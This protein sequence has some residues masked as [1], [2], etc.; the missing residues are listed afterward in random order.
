MASP[1]EP[2]RAA[3]ADDESAV[4][5]SAVAVP[6]RDK[7]T[8]L[9]RSRVI[10]ATAVVAV[11]LA[12]GAAQATDDPL[13][14]ATTQSP[15]LVQIY[16]SP[17][18]EY[19]TPH[20][21]ATFEHSLRWQ[22]ERFGWQPTQPVTVFLKDFSDFGNAGATPTPI[23]TL[24]VEIEPASNDFETDPGGERMASLMNH[25]LVHLATGDIASS[26][27]LFWRHL[28]LGKVSPQPADPESLIYSYLTVPRFNVPRWQLEGAA[29]F[30]ETWMGGGFGRAQGG[31]DEM[32]FRAMVRDHAAFYDPLALESRGIRVDFQV[33][34]NAYLYG[35]RFM[36]W[37]A[38]TYSP[39]QVVTWLRR[40]EGSKRHYAAAFEQVFGLPLDTAWQH[41]IADEQTFQQRNLQGLREHPLTPLKPITRQAL[42]SSSRL[43]FD[44]ASATLYGAFRR[45]GIVEFVGAVDTRNGSVRPLVDLTG[46]VLFSVTA[47][48]FDPVHRTLFYTANNLDQRDLMSF[49][50]RTGRQT[51]LLRR[52][53]IG[54]LVF[55]AADRSLIGV[56]HANGVA[57]IVRVPFPYD[58]WEPLHTF[59]YEV[60]PTNLD[61][62]PDGA[63]LSASVKEVNGD[64]FL[65]VWSLA[66][67]REGRLEQTAQF[68]FGQ[69][70]PEGFVFSPDGRYLYGTSYFTG[71]SN[72]FRCEPATGATEAVTNVETGVFRPLPLADGRLVVL[73]Y[74]GQGF[75]PSIVERPVPLEDVSAIRF[76]GT[77]LAERHPVVTTWQVPPTAATDTLA[78]ATPPRPYDPRRELQFLNAYP[79][80]QGY[81]KTGGLGYRANWSD[82]L[83]FANV[84]LV[85]AVTPAQG[86]K[87]KEQGHAELSGNYL[88]YSGSLSW[89]RS[90]FYDLFGPTERSRKGPRGEGRR[91][92]PADLR[93]LRASRPAFRGR[94]LQRH[95]HAAD[96]AERR[97]HGVDA[98]DRRREPH[99][100]QPAPLARR[101][102]R[103]RRHRG[104]RCAEGQHRARRPHDPG[105]RQRRRR[106]RAAVGPCVA[107]VAQLCR[108]IRRR[109]QQ[110]AGRVLLRR[111]R[112]QPA[113]R[114]R[115]APLSRLRFAARLRHRRHRRAFVRPRDRRVRSPAGDLRVGRPARPVSE[116][117]ASRRLRDR[118]AHRPV[119]CV[120]A[121][122]LRER[123]HA[124]RPAL[125]P[126]A[127]VR[128]D[129]VDRRRRRLPGKQTRAP[130]VD[131]VVEDPLSSSMR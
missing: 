128:S 19:L 43:F 79:V 64:Q 76:L 25:E 78:A 31:Y 12:T 94:A 3:T 81:K 51:L 66:A 8:A 7:A 116:L 88:G 126:A 28:F 85:A 96:G 117:A 32:V 47:L 131:G 27:D 13:G 69:A 83:G 49:D 22:R 71:V 61:V 56:R 46:G 48:A 118:D 58:H 80:L 50:L 15:D 113:R 16:L 90:N 23:N 114:R 125:Q 104:R 74:T 39:E 121:C 115:G 20:V 60:V 54:D 2:L 45:P 129:P 18:L 33:G 67:L 106:A 10:A 82:A 26:D 89:N 100:R 111:V 5:S 53:R 119:Q 70:A 97:E 87:L 72:V 30:M 21:Q 1:I 41:W 92:H 11:S 14:L 42:G 59:D 130:R 127:L 86:L 9:R 122:D 124:G 108:R 77:E 38:L 109:P 40:D 101:G 44:P 29:V 103:G 98:D 65:R 36:T 112:Q 123:R 73:D 99:V 35:T 107:V 120:D 24:R 62:S 4:F 105:A 37:L 91:R 63:S 57:T 6:R 52:A 55:D 68:G 110:P 84:A 34:V 93:P 75:V 102:R 17:Q 95:R